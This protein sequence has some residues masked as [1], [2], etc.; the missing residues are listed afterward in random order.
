MTIAIPATVVVR[1][2]V[3]IAVLVINSLYTITKNNTSP[4]VKKGNIILF[5]GVKLTFF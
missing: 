2:R 5:T 3:V 4:F 1:F